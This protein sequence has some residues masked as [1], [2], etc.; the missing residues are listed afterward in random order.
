MCVCVCACVRACVRACVCVCV[1]ACVCVCVRAC[2]RVHVCVF[3]C[4]CA[5][6]REC[7]CVSSFVSY[8]RYRRI[9]KILAVVTAQTLSR[10]IVNVRLRS[11]NERVVGSNLTLCFYLFIY[12]FPVWDFCCLTFAL[13]DMMM[14]E[15]FYLTNQRNEFVTCYCVTF[16]CWHI[17]PFYCPVNRHHN[18]WLL[19]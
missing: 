5:Q 8:V 6:A 16:L 4:V 18:I 14:V 10:H 1:R 3:V 7:V 9:W 11:D 15:L 19:I 13:F 17:S 12:L 2:A